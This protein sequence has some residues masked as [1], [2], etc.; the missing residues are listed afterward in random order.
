MKC[1]TIWLKAPLDEG[2]PG[3]EHI[4]MV[5]TELDCSDLGKDC[6]VVSIKCMSADPY[7]RGRIKS[8]NPLSG[9]SGSDGR[10]V[11][12]G[13]VSGVVIDSK[14]KDWK[15]GDFFGAA[16]PF[17]T[18]QIL[19]PEARGKT[20]MWK[21]NGMV[22][23]ETLSLGVGVLGMPG[24][25]AYGGLIDILRPIKGQTLFVSAAS[26]AVGSLVGQIGKNVYG[27]QTIG[28]CGGPDKAKFIKSKFGFDESIDYK[29]F[30]TLEAL[31][32][33][34]KRCA[35]KGIDMYFEN[36]GGIFFEAAMKALRPYG[37]IA[38]C[39]CISGYNDKKPPMSQL[40]IGQMIYTFQRIEG[41]VCSPWLKQERGNFL[42][43]MS[44]WLKEGKIKPEETF[45]KG[46]ESW[47]LAFR[48]LFTGKK[49]GKVVV[50]IEDDV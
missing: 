48:S 32:K 42:K 3:P 39:G 44:K 10:R 28:S 30:Q 34:L 13:F 12:S 29:K 47:P 46:I 31:S 33:E 16:L 6:I 50:L 8:S 24:S 40:Y 11:M 2:I 18:I 1:K 45:F 19:S 7:L 5:T 27:L 36:V 49:R 41:F 21:L 43:D 17:S 20:V 26:G 35:P 37:R 22:T 25:T 23:E 14:S 15:K 38:V 4:D 9:S